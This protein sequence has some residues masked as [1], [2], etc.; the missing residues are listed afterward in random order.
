MAHA[1]SPRRL[2]LAGRRSRILHSEQP[3]GLANAF[4]R[5][6]EAVSEDAGAVVTLDADLNHQPEE[7]PE[8]VNALIG[9]SADIVIGSRKVSG[10]I[11]TGAPRWKRT[12][13]D[14]VNRF[15]RRLAGMLVADM[16]LGFRVYSGKAFRQIS[17]SS[18]GFA[19]LPEILIRAHEAGLRIVEE[20][21]TFIFRID[22]E[23]KMK[24]MPTALSY[25]RLFTLRLLT[26]DKNLV[27]HLRVALAGSTRD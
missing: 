8:L 11:T 6:F 19:F 5:G 21:I 10:S 22:G 14:T 16:T 18:I 7:M 27:S 1:R 17:F 12:L 23:S 20:P 26:L 24:L 15:M 4:R 13:S 3:S 25:C 2:R 9:R